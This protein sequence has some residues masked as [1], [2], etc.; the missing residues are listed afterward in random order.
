MSPVTNYAS[1]LAIGK[2]AVLQG[3][4]VRICQDTEAIMKL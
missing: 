1:I 3:N 4:D 2:H